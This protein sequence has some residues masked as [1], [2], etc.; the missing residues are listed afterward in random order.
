MHRLPRPRK[1]WL[2]LTVLIVTVVG[3]GA[4]ASHTIGNQPRAGIACAFHG[5][6]LWRQ[7][8]AHHLGWSAYHLWRATH[9]CRPARWRY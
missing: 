9:N 7:L 8:R 1:R 6:R 4:A 3:L 5:W 2:L